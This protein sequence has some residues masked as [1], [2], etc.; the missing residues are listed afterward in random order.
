MSRPR[1][2]RPKDFDRP[3]PVVRTHHRMGAGGVVTGNDKLVAFFA[4]VGAGGGM[5]AIRSLSRDTAMNVVDAEAMGEACET[6][7]KALEDIPLGESD[8]WWSTTKNYLEKTR[9]WMKDPDAKGKVRCGI[10]RYF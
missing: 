2:R 8:G 5:V 9:E 1:G 6:V 7:E 10:V 3:R 4:A